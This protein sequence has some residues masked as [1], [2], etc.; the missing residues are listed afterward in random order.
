MIGEVLRA[1]SVVI[2]RFRVIGRSGTGRAGVEA[3][4]IDGREDRIEFFVACNRYDVVQ[5]YDGFIKIIIRRSRRR[6]RHFGP[7]GKDHR[8]AA[9]VIS[10]TVSGDIDLSGAIGQF[11]AVSI[12]NGESVRIRVILIMKDDI[13]VF[14]EF[15][16]EMDFLCLCD[17]RDIVEI[18]SGIR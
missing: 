16:V 11:R 10:N 17:R 6:D 4:P 9:A 7:S 14:G 15:G 8:I 1:C 18:I 13:G 5:F 2:I 12:R 3:E